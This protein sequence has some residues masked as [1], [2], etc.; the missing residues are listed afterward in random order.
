YRSRYQAIA[1]AS[2][3]LTGQLDE[4]KVKV[5][6]SEDARLEYERK[7]QIWELDDKSNVA[8][9]RLADLNKQVTDAQ[10]ERLKK[11]AIYDFAKSANSESVSELR[12]DTVLQDLYK[13]RSEAT[14]Q[15][16][17][18]LAQT[19]PNFPKVQRI[20]GQLKEID[21]MIDNEKKAIIAQMGN[22][23]DAARQ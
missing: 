14:G 16:T 15:Y 8:T 6:Q 21:Q 3:W 9:Q 19:G 1:Q 12:S 5:Q 7:N 20:Q 23:Y 2:A 10:T 4:L 22:D 17:E 18:A 13:R 11:Q